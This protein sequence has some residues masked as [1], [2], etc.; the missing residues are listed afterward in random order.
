MTNKEL[1]RN[2]LAE[3]PKC[4][5]TV[6]VTEKAL[7]R[8]KKGFLEA[9]LLDIN[10]HFQLEPIQEPEK[11]EEPVTQEVAVTEVTMS[12]QDIIDNELTKRAE[13]VCAKYT[14]KMNRTTVLNRDNMRGMFYMEVQKKA[15]VFHS[16]EDMVPENYRE[17][18]VFVK[19]NK[20]NPYAVKVTFD[21]L[22]IVLAQYLAR[23]ERVRVARKTK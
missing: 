6:D 16:K 17:T 5:V 20:P 11:E 7:L 4:N 15:V 3:A 21:N 2:I 18:M 12:A 1:A 13:Y 8:E 23:V 9:L 19:G 22:A 10:P 14:P